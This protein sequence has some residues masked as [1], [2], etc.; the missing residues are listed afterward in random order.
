M[1]LLPGRG[2][3]PDRL[4]FV[5]LLL[6]GSGG[7]LLFES[8][9]TL[10]AQA[11]QFQSGFLRQSPEYASDAAALALDSLANTQDVGPGSYWVDIQVNARYFGQREIRFDTDPNGEGLLPCLSPPLLEQMGVRLESLEHPALLQQS[12]VDLRRLIPDARS[13][14]DGS[15]LLLSLSIPQIAMRRDT[16]GRIDPELWDYGIN[17]AFISYQASAQQRSGGRGGSQNSDDLYL[18]SGI[19]L[20][21][22]RLRSNQSMRHD[23]HGK[24]QWTRAYAYA[25]RDLPGVRA[26]LTIGETF[27]GGEVFKSL[28]IKGA[29]IRSDQEMLADTLQGYAPVIRGVAQSRAKLDVLQNGYPIYSTYVSAGPYEIDDLATAGNGELEIVLTEA[30][31][32]VRRFT[33]PYSTISNL[34]REGIW[35]YSAALGRYNSAHESE[36]PWLWQGTL[37]S[38]T[39]WGSTFYGGLMASDFYR[40]GTLG[41][42]RDLGSAGALAFDL[43]HSSADI[44]QPGEP[45]VQGMSHAIKY[46]KSFSTSTNLRFAGY[47][48][49]TEG[50]RDF[51]EAL[52]QRS[53]S[54]DFNGSRR[55]RLEASVHQRVGA[56]S[57]LSL[58]LSHQDYWRSD[59]EQRQFQF[60]FNT[61]YG[62]V[63]YNLYASQSLSNSRDRD[64]DRQIGLSVSVPLDF[65]HSSNATFD[66]QKNGDRHSQRASLS[67]NLDEN[68]LSYRTSIS[69]DDGRQQS[70]ALSAGYQA[71]FG[72][73]GAGF[74][75]GNDYS[76]T[77]INASGAVL[78]HA[79]GIELGPNLGETIGLV[80]VPD[81]PGVGVQNTT[82]VRTNSRGY[83]L[84]PYLRP[85]RYNQIALNTEQ[86]GPQVEID[87]GSA[88]VVPGRGAV[89]KTTFAAR[90]VTRLVITARTLKGQ[91]LPFGA[92]VSDAQ[93]KVMGV[94]G[95]GGQV[96]LATDKHPQT[97][98]VRW[99]EQSEPQCRL[100]I[101]PANMPESEGYRIEELTCR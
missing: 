58:T 56:R 18:N 57:S 2:R 69:N 25:Q 7:A 93:G 52:R 30:D 45:K 55:S 38:G 77:S 19:N 10:A 100:P 20:G 66:L 29:L 85:Y 11:V 79:D 75:Q 36:Q 88:Q 101:D 22:W 49:S 28:P 26:N 61:Q 80:Q 53:R 9:P 90:T 48:Y 78:L 92:Q 89:V 32:Q 62:G 3:V 47:R 14:F 72:N 97:L 44:E 67:G 86:L 46:G 91:P 50:Y 83:A 82:G 65:G 5:H 16:V 34:L 41:I 81:T 96:L 59:H 39:A 84:V 31:G 68:R 74:N 40:A 1:T 6:I 63:T 23:E 4:R 76:T 43:T 12:C 35:K 64:Q 54:T 37:A 15:K 27:T 70:A 24:R 21:P 71:S 13:D 60:N 73:V 33:Q 8:K 94:V 87:N 95:Q 42:A 99:G 17:A 51:D 98:D